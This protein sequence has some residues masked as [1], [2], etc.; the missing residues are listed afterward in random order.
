MVFMFFV[1][2]MKSIAKTQFEDLDAGIAVGCVIDNDTGL[3][4]AGAKVIYL[5]PGSGET[6]QQVPV[7]T[8]ASGCY[9]L[10]VPV[11][12]AKSK[13][14]A[15][16]ILTSSIFSIVT[17][18]KSV[19]TKTKA[20]YT[21]ALG[22][23]IEKDGYKP[24]IGISDVI[25]GDPK[26]FEIYMRPVALAPSG[27]QGASIEMGSGSP[28][29]IK[30]EDFSIPPYF[31]NDVKYPVDITAVLPKGIPPVFSV[32]FQFADTEGTILSGDKKKK[33]DNY[34]TVLSNR[35]ETPDGTV[36]FS[37]EMKASAKLI[38]SENY[39]YAF[40][41]TGDDWIGSER[42]PSYV[43]S[44]ENEKRAA[45]LF[46]EGFIS[47]RRKDYAKA[48]DLFSQALKENGSMKLCRKYLFESLSA[49]NKYDEAMQTL[50][51][52]KADDPKNYHPF[53]EASKIMLRQ[54]KY[55]EARSE[56]SK[57]NKLDKKDSWAYNALMLP[58]QSLEKLKS[59]KPEKND[60]EQAAGM[61]ISTA[62]DY[63][64]ALSILDKADSFYPGDATLT[65][66]RAQAYIGQGKNDE[67][68]P[69]LEKAGA[70]GVSNEDYAISLAEALASHGAFDKAATALKPLSNDSKSFRL[71]H[72]LAICDL[73]TGNIPEAVGSFKK[74][75]EVSFSGSDKLREGGQAL[76]TG[77]Y[78]LYMQQTRVYYSGF[79]YDEASDDFN[80]VLSQEALATNPSDPLAFLLAGISLFNLGAYQQAAENLNKAVSIDSNLVQAHQ[81]LTKTYAAL[82]DSKAEK[83]ALEKYIALNPADKDAGVKLSNISKE[84]NSQNTPQKQPEVKQ[85]AASNIY[86]IRVI[87]KGAILLDYDKTSDLQPGAV[88]DV[89]RVVKTIDKKTKKT[90]SEKEYSIAELEVLEIKDD[91][92]FANIKSIKKDK[93]VEIS[94]VVRK[95]SK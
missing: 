5:P 82:S 80:Y 67:A 18:P 27:S 20:I 31:E 22:L 85:V 60:F 15:G 73:K 68:L 16:K 84:K 10:S 57:V 24:F 61:L 26:P 54:K 38:P 49:Q 45:T 14:N 30:I 36:K 74:A 9:R 11:G 17:N 83:A 52:W 13:V 77:L 58:L 81:Y 86:K 25:F 43:T 19:T 41:S 53:I 12:K 4:I 94:D 88:L 92:I 28:T 71:H 90:I 64:L 91:T 1:I 32:G 3:S 7:L 2:P 65:F 93:K 42:F 35:T 44:K 29:F 75:I 8:D 40:I 46:H 6:S 62:G 69:L 39:L 23:R 59:E 76:N 70:S 89:F 37:G 79:S 66:L 87:S 48:A 51:Q 34:R 95:K 72:L 55:P 21:S 33:I 78:T 47:Y 50:D 63:D 56:L